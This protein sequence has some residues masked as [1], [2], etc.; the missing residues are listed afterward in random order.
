M[1]EKAAKESARHMSHLDSINREHKSDQDRLDSE[2]RKKHE[3]ESKLKT[4]GHE[5][6][7]GQKRMDKLA[8]H[9][10]G[11]EANLEEQEKN[12]QDLQG[13]VGCSKD[14]I[15]EVQNNLEEVV[16]ELGD[17]RL[18]KHEDKRRKK[19]QE[20]VDN[21]KCLY[22]GVYDRIINLCQQIHKKYNVAITKLLGRYMEAIVVDSE[23]T[24]RQC[25]QGKAVHPKSTAK[26][27]E[28]TS[29][30][31][32]IPVHLRC[33][34]GHLPP[35]EEADR[36]DRL[37]RSMFLS[38]GDGMLDGVDPDDLTHANVMNGNVKY[39]TLN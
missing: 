4:K 31:T 28:V 34:S 23:E 33:S 18:D 9:I 24:A 13:D 37:G 15:Q 27:A 20:I 17:A 1:K 38:T 39:K 30:W 22:K 16:K 25:I 26:F 8:K 5:L 7:E 35:R 2:N 10:R 3:I 29:E 6:E 11:S 19:K 14:R 36:I 32:T 21:F 12:I